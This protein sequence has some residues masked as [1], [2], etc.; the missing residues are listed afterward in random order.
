MDTTACNSMVSIIIAAYNVQNYIENCLKSVQK[1]TYP[2]WECIVIDDGS[3]D[4]TFRVAMSIAE[5]DERFKI[6]RQK[7]IGVSAA[8]NYGL[9]LARG[10]FIAFMDSDDRY[11]YTFLEKATQG[12]ENADLFISGIHNVQVDDNG[13]EI[14]LESWS[15][16]KLYFENKKELAA[17]YIRNHKLLLYSNCNKL[18]RNSILKANDIIFDESLQFGEDRVFNYTYL[19]YANK[20]ITTE[21]CFYYYY[22]RNRASL[23]SQFRKRHIVELMHLHQ[24]KINW[25][26]CVLDDSYEEELE[27]F[28]HYDIAKEYN[29]A[30]G[31]VIKN[32]HLLSEE[33]LQEEEKTLAAFSEKYKLSFLL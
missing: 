9:K 25:L 3:E 8:R 28:I 15:I 17:Y 4:E 5:D 24:E 21:E 13:E 14:P 12:I 32:R 6:V 7:H 30:K 23:S 11:D 27:D 2:N 31:M 26:R 1:Q 19:Q 16:P 10:E 22:H 29:N 33:A 18:Y 20:A